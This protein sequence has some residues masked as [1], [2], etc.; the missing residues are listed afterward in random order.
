MTTMNLHELI[1]SS[2]NEE[3][4]KDLCYEL[5]V[6]YEDL[7]A[8]GKAGK[9]RELIV[10]CQK[11]GR[12]S[13]LLTACQTARPHV[14]WPNLA[15]A[16]P[17]LEIL[18]GEPLKPL[19]PFEPETLL[20]PAGSFVMGSNDPAA[21]AWEQPQHTVELP[22]YYIGKYPITNQQYAEFLS[23]ERAVLEPNKEDWFNRKPQPEKRNFPVTSVSWLDAQAYCRWLSGVTNKKYRLPT[24]AE[25]E[26]AARGENGR[27]Y[28]WGDEWQNG[29]CNAGGGGKTA[30]T[31]YD[32]F[33]SPY[34]CADMVGNVQ[35]WVSTLWGED[36]KQC[37]YPYPYQ[38][39]DGREHPEADPQRPR[40]RRIHRGGA[41]NDE[42]S[43]CRCAAR[44][45]ARA[46][47]ASNL[48]GFRVV[49]VE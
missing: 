49:L 39:H 41:F 25:W 4:V 14:E 7:P 34:G 10:Y 31:A 32:D 2:F 19:L 3:E 20:V 21:P 45:H 5:G 26:K 29:R 47:A 40:L 44:D 11:N 13:P 24:E 9:V 35:E 37:A 27:I 12:I 8:L 30:V 38:P 15:Q 48:R 43:Q 23:R 33:P 1:R 18:L 17:A 42:L 16:V 6:D 36:R 46:D 22:A 28:P